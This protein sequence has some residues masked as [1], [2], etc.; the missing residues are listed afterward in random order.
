MRRTSVDLPSPG[1][2]RMKAEGLEMSRARWNQLTD[3]LVWL[4]PHSLLALAAESRA[5]FER[6][7]AEDQRNGV[8][9]FDPALKGLFP[10]AR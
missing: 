2:P 4:T 7:M 3:A 9:I 5:G 1:L 6:L 8:G 10:K